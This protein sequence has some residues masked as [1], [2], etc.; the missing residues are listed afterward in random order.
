MSRVDITTAIKYGFVVVAYFVG[1]LIVGGVVAAIGF[2]IVGIGS[3]GF[4]GTGGGLGAAGGGVLALVGIVVGIIGYVIII[5]AAFGIQ[6]K[7]IS[8]GVA[9]GIETAGG[10]G[11]DRSTAGDE[12]P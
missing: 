4:D 5:G 3:T 7:I 11:G 9:R 1:I 6:Y 2:G 8:D 12:R 10:L